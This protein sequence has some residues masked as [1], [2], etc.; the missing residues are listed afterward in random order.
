MDFNIFT[1]FTMGR[2]AELEA[3]LAGLR[4]DLYQRMLDEV[5]EIA[6]TGDAAILPLSP[7]HDR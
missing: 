7:P 1:Y 5:A 4:V 2:R 6:A 3:G